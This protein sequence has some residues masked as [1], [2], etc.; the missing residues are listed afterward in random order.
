MAL[1]RAPSPSQHLAD[2]YASL[3]AALPHSWERPAGRREG[4]CNLH[5]GS[6]DPGASSPLPS[7]TNRIRL[8]VLP[9]CPTRPL[10]YSTS[11]NS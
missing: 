11:N 7:Y 2:K 10:T 1:A 5:K 6:V 9:P 8:W 4:E 3:V